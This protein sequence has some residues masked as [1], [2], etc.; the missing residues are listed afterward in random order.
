MKEGWHF[1][2][3]FAVMLY[4]L[5]WLRY[6]AQFAALYAII[7][8]VIMVF[9]RYPKDW[10]KVLKQTTDSMIEGAQ[11]AIAVTVPCACIGL[12][13]GVVTITGVGLEFSALM[14]AQSGGNLFPLLIIMM[15]ACLILGL[16]VPTTAAYVLV[17]ILAVPAMVELGV[18]MMAAHLFCFYFAVIS[19]ITPPVALAAF[20]AAGIAKANPFK[21]GWT[22]TRLGIAGFIVPY[23]FV[24][25]PGL[26]LMGTVSE[27]LIA[28]VSCTLGIIA[29]SGA[30]QKYMLG[31]L[32]YWLETGALYLAAFGLVTPNTTLDIMGYVVFFGFIIYRYAINK[33]NGLTLSQ[34]F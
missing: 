6:E 34:M 12:I 24:Y 13:V 28:I 29:L 33:R 30:L 9:I 25:Q 17:S 14:R 27:I 31:K 16:G 21:T 18:P 15:V 4:F 3:P 8:M 5:L 20:T 32:N 2:I 7:S 1:L 10:K 23:V 19:V 22:A 26:L 11:S